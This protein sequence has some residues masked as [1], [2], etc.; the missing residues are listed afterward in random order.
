MEQKEVHVVPFRSKLGSIGPSPLAT[1]GRR[2]G[3]GRGLLLAGPGPSRTRTFGF[4]PAGLLDPGPSE[5]PE[6]QF[7]YLFLKNRD[8]DQ[9]REP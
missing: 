4:R 2:R 8:I 1:E 6:L 7:W 9:L 5:I 3:R